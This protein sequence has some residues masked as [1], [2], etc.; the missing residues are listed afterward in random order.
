[1]T[2]LALRRRAIGRRAAR[3]PRLALAPHRPLVVGRDH[4]AGAVTATFFERGPPRRRLLHAGRGQRADHR[5][6]RLGRHRVLQVSAVCW[7]GTPFGQTHHAEIHGSDGTIYAVND[8]DTVQ[9]V[10]GCVLVIRA[11]RGCCRCPRLWYGARRAPVHD[12]YR[13]VFRNGD[14]MTR[15]GERG[16][17]RTRASP[18]SPRGARVQQLLDA[19]ARATAQAA[20]SSTSHHD[21]P[22]RRL[23]GVAPPWPACC[24]PG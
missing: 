14:T 24:R 20:A 3:R 23:P 2:T 19:A 5:P 1:M 10:R 4:R 7:E 18:T 17:R 6:L 15:S 11:G 22:R 12:T 8:W 9:E 13:D 16:R 21:R